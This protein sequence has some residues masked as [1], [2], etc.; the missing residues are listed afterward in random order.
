M[1]N[2]SSIK[3]TSASSWQTTRPIW[4]FYIKWS[5]EYSTPQVTSQL[6][7]RYISQDASST[8]VNYLI[9]YYFKQYGDSD[10][11]G[12]QLLNNIWTVFENIRGYDDNSLITRSYQPDFTFVSFIVIWFDF[13]AQSQS[14]ILVSCSLSL[15][16]FTDMKLQNTDKA[17]F[18]QFQKS[19]VS[20]PKYSSI[21][22]NMLAPKG[23][24][25]S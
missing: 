2:F 14:L 13:K 6:I 21:M 5:G 4:L 23:P 12:G 20:A 15:D 16:L 3:M 17:Q 25:R 11:A 9:R 7:Q 8:T 19:C 1:A 18:H 22:N 24:W 10:T